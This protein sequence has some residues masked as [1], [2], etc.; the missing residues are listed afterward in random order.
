MRS[1]ARTSFVIA[2]LWASAA[3]SRVDAQVT[4]C[5][6]LPAAE[7][8]QILGKPAVAK[9]KVISTDEGDCSYLG[10][11]FDIHTELLKSASGWSA[12]VKNLVKQGRAEAVAGIGDEAAF[13]KDGN[14]DYAL[15]SRKGDRIVTITMYASEGTAA[16]L[17]P[18]L[19][20]MVTA[21]VG[22][23]H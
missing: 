1:S 3:V 23:L 11:G 16:E 17:K 10:S 9:A 19:I 6:L 14:G 2:I 22:K 5:S 20:K 13:S 7:A 4:A 12:S 15:V 18:K 8:A 21:A